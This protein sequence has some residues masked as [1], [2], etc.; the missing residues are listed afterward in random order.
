MK[1]NSI[2]I[3]INSKNIYIGSVKS[4]LTEAL[5]NEIDGKFQN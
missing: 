4:D 2:D 3:L 1:E 5:I